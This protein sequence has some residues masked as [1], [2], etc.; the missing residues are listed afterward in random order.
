M[1]RGLLN[2]AAIV[3]DG[4]LREMVEERYSSFD[5]GEGKRFE[6]GKMG[7]EELVEYAKRHGEPRQTSGRQELY[8]TLVSLFCE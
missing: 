4:T 8:E 7:L 1:A 3:E 2:A 6:E 5:R